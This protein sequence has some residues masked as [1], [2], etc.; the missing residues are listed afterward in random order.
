MKVF[1]NVGKNVPIRRQRIMNKMSENNGLCLH[2]DLL[3]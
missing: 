2:F 3:P 1:F